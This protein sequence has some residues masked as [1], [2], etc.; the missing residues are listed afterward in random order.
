MIWSKLPEGFDPEK[1]AQN[2]ALIITCVGGSIM[3]LFGIGPFAQDM[4]QDQKDVAM[5][6]L[7]VQPTGLFSV[8]TKFG[9]IVKASK[10]LGD[11]I[12][13]IAEGAVKWNELPKDFDAAKAA[14]NIALI[15]TCVG[16]SIMGLFGAGPYA[17]EM[18][19]EQ[20]KVA[21]EM[22]KVESGGL[23]RSR[24]TKFGM[25]VE[26]SKGLGEVITKIAEGSIKWNQLPKDFNANLAAQ[27]ISLII[28]CVGSAIMGL[29]GVGPFANK[30][31]EQDKQVAKEMFMTDNIFTGNNKFKRIV[32][33]VSK[34]GGMISSIMEGVQSYAN[35]KIPTKFDTSGKPTEWRP[36]SDEDFKNATKNIGK[37]ILTLGRAVARVG[38]SETF[39]GLFA[40]ERLKNISI[41][42]GNVSKVLSPIANSIW[43]YSTGMFPVLE[44][45][46]GKLI[47]KGYFNANKHGGIDKVIKN[48]T[49]N[50]GKV[51]LGL[52][53]KIGELID[54]D[55]LEYLIDDADDLKV[56]TES[57]TLLTKTISSVFGSF[58]N[59][60]TK[61]PI[62]SPLMDAFIISPFETFVK[63]ILFKNDDND[64]VIKNMVEWL[65]D[66]GDDEVEDYA[67]GLEKLSNS[68]KV[69][70]TDIK[71]ILDLNIDKNQVGTIPE[72]LRKYL[73]VVPYIKYFV[74][75][76]NDDTSK[77]VNKYID[78]VNRFLKLAK[79]T[80]E[81][82]AE[83][84]NILRDGINA[85][86]AATSTIQE[87]EKFEN[88][89]KTLEKY[90]QAV[91]SIQ[92]SKVH[93]LTNLAEAV[94]ELGDK[95]GNIDNFTNVLAHRLSNV[96][97]KL[98][99][100][101]KEA[102]AVIKNADTLHKKREELIK[103]SV[104]NITEL[105]KQEMTVNIKKEE[106]STDLVTSPDSGDT[107]STTDTSTSPSTSSSS[108][109]ST[110]TPDTTTTK[111]QSKS[112]EKSGSSS[113]IMNSKI[114][115]IDKNI[116]NIWN[117]VKKL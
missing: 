10:G 19:Q 75:L 11:V 88:H 48:A 89:T 16:G 50:I 67:N 73:E 87:S 23:F 91:N 58:N 102:E 59:I 95:I 26:A 97:I 66:E 18:T 40:G 51:I 93:S 13:E 24:K 7:K 78:D 57:I 41:A 4:T 77:V 106:E 71:S 55:D 115:Q 94:T 34:I 20:K 113:S 52:G 15:I 28:T 96:L 33:S 109:P 108:T 104:I 111:P 63:G 70:F 112:R 5:E 47:T 100:Q 64:Q 46:D 42:I 12:K 103:K 56:F 69:L 76:Y 17:N 31:S 86:Y 83:K 90:V 54:D 117:K 114:D 84:Y 61:F 39:K 14:S 92:I 44:F 2:I 36:M 107:T 9:M 3:G 80:D 1:A 110:T 22:L 45:K 29:Y 43:M 53:K 38:E 25:V 32:D 72:M 27:N 105:M 49:D 65:I 101:I 62:M 116:T 60:I 82:Y 81:E 35:L 21:M 8:D 68:I 85:I 74:N 79:D 6:M 30:L 37:L 99:A 98:T